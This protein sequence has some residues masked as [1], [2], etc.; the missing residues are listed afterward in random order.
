MNLNINAWWHLCKL[1]QRQSKAE[2][3]NMVRYSEYSFMSDYETEYVLKIE[4]GG[5]ASMELY[6]NRTIDGYDYDHII[7]KSRKDLITTTSL[8]WTVVCLSNVMLL[9]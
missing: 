7:K 5:I 8:D 1:V 4:N 2:R 3:G 9:E 6:H